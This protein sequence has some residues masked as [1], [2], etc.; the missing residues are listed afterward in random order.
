MNSSTLRLSRIA[1]MLPPRSLRRA[2]P[3]SALAAAAACATGRPPSGSP[4]PP[5]SPSRAA[6]GAAADTAATVAQAHFTISADSATVGALE[7]QGLEQ[8]HV[9]ADLQFL[10]D[11]I[12]PRL[13][14]SAGQRRANAWTAA[15]F[16]EYGLDSVW[17][18]SWPFGRAWE[19]GPITLTLVAPHTQQLIRGVVGL[20]A[21]HERSGERRRD[22]RKR[23]HAGRIRRAVRRHG[24]REVGDDSPSGIGV[25]LGWPTDDES[26]LAGRGLGPPVSPSHDVVPRS[27]RVPAVAA[28]RCWLATA[29]WVSSPMGPRN[30]P[31]S[32]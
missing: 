7:A 13:T 1:A 8:S 26:R 28:V 15:K 27:G 31:C 19:R 11:V 21:G 24:P 12:G 16:R 17:T 9:P 32:R 20:G 4:L 5:N 18:E 3:L 2:V 30:S 10:S 22:L 25:E 6:A 29:R 23:P 14:G